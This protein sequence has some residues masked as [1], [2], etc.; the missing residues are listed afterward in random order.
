[1]RRR[2]GTKKAENLPALRLRDDAFSIAR[3]CPRGGR[4]HTLRIQFLCEQEQEAAGEK[5]VQ[6][7]AGIGIAMSVPQQKRKPCSLLI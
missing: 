4:I 5:R 6:Q 1:M 7:E 3:H 2:K